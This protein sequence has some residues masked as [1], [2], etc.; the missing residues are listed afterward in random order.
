MS[1]RINYKIIG[2]S[3][4]KKKYFK[5]L[6]DFDG[7]ESHIQ[8]D[9]NRYYNFI[10]WHFSNENINNSRFILKHQIN[11]RIRMSIACN[12]KSSINMNHIVHRKANH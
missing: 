9:R 2:F 4:V 8:L 10:Q 12:N 11:I 5:I 7:M 3:L 1:V 6:T